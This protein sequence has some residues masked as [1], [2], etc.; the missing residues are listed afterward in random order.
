MNLSPW[1]RPP[2]SSP[3]LSITV[4]F[5]VANGHV[6]IITLKLLIQSCHQS[7]DEENAKS[8]TFLCVGKEDTLA[9]DRDI[10]RDGAFL[11]SWKSACK[12]LDEMVAPSSALE[13]TPSPNLSPFSFSR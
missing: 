1:L 6:L 13:Q 11:D 3:Q 10:L 7:V 12:L 2:P 8:V 5:C 4:L 9:S